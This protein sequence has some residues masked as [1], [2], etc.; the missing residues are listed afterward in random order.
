VATVSDHN[1]YDDPSWQQ[2]EMV[3]G[4]RPLQSGPVVG[5]DIAIEH[6]GL[7]ANESR[8][9]DCI[10]QEP[11]EVDAR[12]WI[13]MTKPLTQ[14]TSAVLWSMAMLPLSTQLLHLSSQMNRYH[15]LAMQLGISKETADAV[16]TEEIDKAS[17]LP[18]RCDV[19]LNARNRLI[20]L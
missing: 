1:L 8:P 9:L 2:D 3:L 13:Q 10:Y 16:I 15:E 18:Y 5:V 14:Q 4:Y 17:A 6:L 7:A 20:D 11:Y 19:F 12:K